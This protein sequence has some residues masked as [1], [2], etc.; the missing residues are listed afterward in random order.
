MIEIIRLIESEGYMHAK[1]RIAEI[2]NL[3][4]NK[5]VTDFDGNEN[6]RF[7]RH[8]RFISTHHV[9]SKCNSDYCRKKTTNS[10]ENSWPSLVSDEV[11]TETTFEEIISVWLHDSSEP[12]CHRN[13]SGNLPPNEY[14]YWADH[15]TEKDN[16][17]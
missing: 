6:E 8:L 11:L 12:P 14:I 5:S 3:Q 2:N 7:T 17:R 1:Y 9:S 4:I 13:F 15:L 16:E 10:L